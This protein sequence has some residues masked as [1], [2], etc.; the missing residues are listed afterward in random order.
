M[1]PS[2]GRSGTRTCGHHQAH[3]NV[4]LRVKLSGMRDVP[5]PIRCEHVGDRDRGRRALQCALS[6]RVHP[7][8]DECLNAVARGVKEDVYNESLDKWSAGGCSKGTW[9]TYSSGRLD[10]GRRSRSQDR[11]P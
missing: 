9:T 3:Q 6:A 1:S 7:V 10:P 11:P 4:F 2:S 8:V 5:V